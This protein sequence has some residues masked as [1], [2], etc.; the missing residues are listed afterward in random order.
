MLNQPTSSPMMTRMLGRRCWAIAWVIGSSMTASAARTLR[1]ILCGGFIV[2]S[3]FNLAIEN[4]VKRVAMNE[5]TALLHWRVTWEGHGCSSHD[6]YDV[7][8]SWPATLLAG[9]SQVATAG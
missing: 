3:P 9:G 8:S 1:V 6:L 7:S 4:G 5:P 2:W